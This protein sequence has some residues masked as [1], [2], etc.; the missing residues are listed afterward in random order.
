MFTCTAEYSKKK[1]L[2]N[3]FMRLVPIT[4]QQWFKYYSRSLS[5]KNIVLKFLNKILAGHF[6]GWMSI[7]NT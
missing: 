6:C 1:T 4:K 5:P 3:S 7:E 2:F